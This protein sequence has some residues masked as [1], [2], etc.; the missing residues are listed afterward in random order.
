MHLKEFHFRSACTDCARRSKLFV[1]LVNILHVKGQVYLYCID[2]WWV[3]RKG[4]IGLSYDVFLG[5]IRCIP[6]IH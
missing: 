5:I 1:L 3:V 4:C 2:S 6:E